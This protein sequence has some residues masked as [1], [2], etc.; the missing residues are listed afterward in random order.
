MYSVAG[1]PPLTLASIAAGCDGLIIEMHPNPKK[2][3]VDPLQPLNFSQFSELN[4]K[5]KKLKKFFNIISNL[6]SSD[7]LFMI[8]RRFSWLFVGSLIKYKKSLLDE[9]KFKIDKDCSSTPERTPFS[10]ASSY[11]AKEYLSADVIENPLFLLNLI[12]LLC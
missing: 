2:S 11:K 5:I 1:E 3:M 4:L 12:P 9:I 6:L 7:I 8:F 10:L